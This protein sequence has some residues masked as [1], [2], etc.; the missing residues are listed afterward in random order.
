MPSHTFDPSETKILQ[1]GTQEIRLISPGASH[2]PDLIAMY[3]PDLELLFGGCGVKAGRTLGYLGDADL[4]SWPAAIA[5]LKELPTRWVIPGH[6]S[7]VDPGL[8]DHTLDL[9]AAHEETD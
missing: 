2:S 3:I 8:L 5:R 9:L 4:E 6:G 1:F 7:R